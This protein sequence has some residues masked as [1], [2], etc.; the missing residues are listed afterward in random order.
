[1]RG[2]HPGGC[3]SLSWQ[4]ATMKPPP[5]VAEGPFLL[6]RLDRPRATAAYALDGL[7]WP[8]ACANKIAGNHCACSTQAAPAVYSDFFPALNS[9]THSAHELVNLLLRGCCEV[10]HWDP[11]VVHALLYHGGGIRRALMVLSQ[12]D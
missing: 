9:L 12:R 2:R 8:A 7:L 3:P 6:V 5:V 11:E 1:M 4:A 10:A